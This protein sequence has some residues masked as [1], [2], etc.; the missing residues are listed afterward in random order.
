MK[1]PLSGKRIAV[2]GFNARPLACSMKTAGAEVYVSDYWGDE[3]LSSCCYRWVSVLNPHPNQRHRTELEE[4]VHRSLAQNL[5]D[6]FDCSN[7]D[8]VIVGSSFDDHPESLKLIEEVCPLTG[9]SSD[10]FLRARDSSK[11]ARLA[12]QVDLLT[13]ERHSVSSLSEALKSAE[14][15]SYPCLIRS[16]ESGGGA[17][18]RFVRDSNCMEDIGKRILSSE[19]KLDRI[20]EQYIPGLDISCSVLGTGDDAITLSLQGQ[21]IGLPSAGRNCDFIYCGNYFPAPV[22]TEITEHLRSACAYIC[23]ELGLL[24]SNGVDL[25]TDYDGAVWLMEVNPRIQGTIEMLESSSNINVSHMHISACEGNLPVRIPTYLPAVK[26]IVYSRRAGT[27]PDLS[28]WKGT[29]DRSP[30]GV[31]VN[32]GDPICTIVES[33]APLSQCYG[34]VCERAASI[35]ASVTPLN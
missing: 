20:I 15:I 25:V 10:L 6:N 35:Q 17:G 7:M 31:R 30:R 5:V 33:S 16:H 24:G 34:V 27:L 13:P 26:M 8:Y 4:P 2:A 3:D 12:K 22:D 1:Q 23:A 28:Q 29:H 19:G 11:V 18:I 9:N 21:L 14:Q 32:R